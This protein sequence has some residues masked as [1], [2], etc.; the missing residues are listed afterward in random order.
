MVALIA[1]YALPTSASALPSYFEC[2]NVGPGAGSYTDA[3]CQ[4]RT[5]RNTGKFEAVEGIGKGRPFKGK[6]GESSFDVPAVGGEILCKSGKEA[7]AVTSPTS[8]G[9]VTLLLKGCETL[10][11]QCASP[12]A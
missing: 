3:K 4:N 5:G 12:G 7:G 8:V 1:V 6:A 10:R 2:K 11:K 9:K